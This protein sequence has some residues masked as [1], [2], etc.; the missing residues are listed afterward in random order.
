MRT[1]EVSF[2]AQVADCEPEHREFVELREDAVLEG[3][4]GRERLELGVQ[5]LAMAF[6]R[7]RF[8]R[9]SGGGGDG[10]QSGPGPRRA[11]QGYERCAGRQREAH[12]AD[13]SSSHRSP[14]LRAESESE[15]GAGCS[16]VEA[17]S[18]R[19]HRHGPGTVAGA[20]AARPVRVLR[21]GEH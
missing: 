4:E 9:L 18:V 15:A 6:A 19:P 16:R 2:D 5:T 8:A 21:G 3:Q 10:G 14:V 11:A 20:P 17:R 13:R 7:V 12:A 1:S